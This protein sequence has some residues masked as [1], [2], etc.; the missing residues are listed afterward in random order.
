MKKCPKWWANSVYEID[1]ELL[2][3]AGKKVILFDLDNTITKPHNKLPLPREKEL[4]ER[5]KKDFRIFIVSNNS[6]KRVSTFCK[7]L[8]IPFLARAWKPFT[9]KT[10]RFLIGNNINLDEAVFVGDQIYTDVHFAARIHMDA[11]LLE[12]ITRN[13]QIHIKFKRFFERRIKKHYHKSCDITKM[14][15]VNAK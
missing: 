5:V 2:K 6:Y 9:A 3:K 15:E 13:E 4:V 7:E 12:R 14:G 8:D 11:L 1:F 10:K